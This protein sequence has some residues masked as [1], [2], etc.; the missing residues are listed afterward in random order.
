MGCRLA[1]KKHSRFKSFG[2]CFIEFWHEYF[3]STGLTV[4]EL[5]IKYFLSAVDIVKL[6]DLSAC[7]C[8]D[9]VKTLYPEPSFVC[10]YCQKSFST[11]AEL[12]VH[13][14]KTENKSQRQQQLEQFQCA[15]CA[16]N[17][18]T[19]IGLIRHLEL[20]TR[21]Y[22][23]EICKKAVTLF[24][25]DRHKTSLG[26]LRRVKIQAQQKIRKIKK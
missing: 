14:A 11:V 15:F 19:K 17:L 25:V 3:Q 7:T 13:V 18:R 5:P 21:E 1:C 12:D 23:C 16:K 20:H 8:E 22:E 4:R 2:R 26:H 6:C 9:L 10:N 24:D